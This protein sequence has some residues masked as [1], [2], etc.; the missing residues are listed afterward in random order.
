MIA[1]G[2]PSN[3]CDSGR[4][5]PTGP[6]HRPPRLEACRRAGTRLQ[7]LAFRS[8]PPRPGR[9]PCSNGGGH[10]FS[11]LADNRRTMLTIEPVSQSDRASSQLL[12]F[13]LTGTH[14]SVSLF[15][16]PDISSGERKHHEHQAGMFRS[17]DYGDLSEL[18]KRDTPIFLADGFEDVTYRCKGC[19]L[20]IKR[21]FKR[22]S[23]AWELVTLQVSSHFAHE[24]K[25]ENCNRSHWASLTLIHE[26]RWCSEGNPVE[27]VPEDRK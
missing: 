13:R 24:A 17:A 7:L 6:M 27:R 16:R 8:R 12:L 10:F 18:Q 23:G 22:R 25:K 4:T 2:G 5:R 26:R 9:L 1:S 15:A 20:D 21:A 14:S 19:R 11:T 3:S